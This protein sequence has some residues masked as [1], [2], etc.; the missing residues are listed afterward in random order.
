MSRRGTGRAPQVIGY[1]KVL[2]AWHGGHANGGTSTRSAHRLHTTCRPLQLR[3]TLGYLR[4]RQVAPETFRD[5]DLITAGSLTSGDAA[6]SWFAVEM[7]TVLTGFHS[8][9]NPPTGELE[10]CVAVPNESA[11]RHHSATRLR[12]SRLRRH[13][14]RGVHSSLKERGRVKGCPSWGVRV[15]AAARGHA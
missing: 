13:M 14:L 8:V 7:H 6:T 10:V 1:S 3:L 9:N 5:T 15:V 2:D 11:S 4:L 12:L